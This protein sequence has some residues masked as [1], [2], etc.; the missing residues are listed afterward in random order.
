VRAI[1]RD[2][3]QELITVG[4]TKDTEAC[5]AVLKK[6]VDALNELDQPTGFI[7]SVERDAIVQRVEEL[8]SL[9]GLDNLDERLTGH[10]DW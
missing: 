10:R 2:A 8:A 9:V 1:F 6:V 5:A 3:T 7:E 4:G